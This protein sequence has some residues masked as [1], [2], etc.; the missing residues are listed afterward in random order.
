MGEQAEAGWAATVGG[1]AAQLEGGRS[2]LWQDVAQRIAVL[3]AAPAA[4][5]GEHFVQVPPPL[6]LAPGAPTLPGLIPAVVL[7]H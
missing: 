4:F 6:P 1:L 2:R 5:N 3:L 7:Q